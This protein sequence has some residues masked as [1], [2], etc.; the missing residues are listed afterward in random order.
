M[1]LF[2]WKLAV[3]TGA[4]F[5]STLAPA[6]SSAP[7]VPPVALPALPAV[8]PPLPPCA[9]PEPLR[10]S[11]QALAGLNPGEKGESLAV[12]VRLYQLKGTG[13]LQGA[14]FDDLLDHDKETL[15]D[16]LAASTEVTINPGERLEPSIVRNPDATYLAGVALFRRPAGTTWRALQRLPPPDPQYCHPLVVSKRVLAPRVVPVRFVLDENRIDLR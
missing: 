15:G 10:L 4:A 1:R 6:C 9:A 3:L 14:G 11:V 12:V 16:E 5:A 13:K 7:P 2:R 8:P